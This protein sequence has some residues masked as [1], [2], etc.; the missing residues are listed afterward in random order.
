MIFSWNSSYIALFLFRVFK[1]FARSA[2]A[3][4]ISKQHPQ[5]N[6]QTPKTYVDAKFGDKNIMNASWANPCADFK[7]D[8]MVLGKNYEPVLQ[9]S[10]G[11]DGVLMKLSPRA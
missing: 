1:T 11:A 2:L 7:T 6:Q 9:K 4:K 10:V 5:L 3:V 8:C